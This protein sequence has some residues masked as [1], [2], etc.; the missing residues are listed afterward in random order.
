MASYAAIIDYRN[1]YRYSVSKLVAACLGQ[2]EPPMC[3]V[4]VGRYVTGKSRLDPMSRSVPT[5]SALLGREGSDLVIYLDFASKLSLLKG[6]F[7]AAGGISR[8]MPVNIPD[9]VI[10]VS[11]HTMLLIESTSQ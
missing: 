11:F 9:L 1:K 5:S 3:G 7:N 6:N 2:I 4:G 10:Q 8:A